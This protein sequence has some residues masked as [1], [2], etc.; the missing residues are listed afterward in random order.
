MRFV[1]SQKYACRAVFVVPPL[2]VA[3]RLAIIRPRFCAK[4]LSVMVCLNIP[5]LFLSASVTLKLKFFV[6]PG[7]NLS[8][9]AVIENVSPMLRSGCRPK[10]TCAYIVPEFAVMSSPSKNWSNTSG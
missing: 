4:M 7:E 6:V 2:S 8:G 5:S 1:L 9:Y 3:E 10:V